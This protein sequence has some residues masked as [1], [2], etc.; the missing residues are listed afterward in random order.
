MAVVTNAENMRVMLVGIERYGPPIGHLAG[1][2]EHVLRYVRWAL[3]HGVPAEQIDVFASDPDGDDR[4]ASEANERLGVRLV[5]PATLNSIR[6]Y[7]KGEL[8]TATEQRLLLMW[9]GHG[10]LFS[11]T[12]TRLLYCADTSDDDPRVFSVAEM[13]KFLRSKQVQN[14]ERQ[15]LLFDVCA[16][17]TNLSHVQVPFPPSEVRFSL[18]S[19]RYVQE[20]ISAAR[21]GLSVTTGEFSRAMHDDVLRD[22]TGDEWPPAQASERVPERVRMTYKLLYGD[23]AD[24]GDELESPESQRDLAAAL[25]D[26]NVVAIVGGHAR[27]PAWRDQAE[28]AEVLAEDPT[29]R[30]P[31]HDR[32]NLAM[33]AEYVDRRWANG[34]AVKK[35]RPHLT[36]E[37]RTDVELRNGIRLL[38]RLPIDIYLTTAYDD[39]L[40]RALRERNREPTIRSFGDDLSNHEKPTVDRPLIFHLYGHLSEGISD[41]NAAVTEL[42]IHSRNQE[43]A[44]DGTIQQLPSLVRAALGRRHLYAGFDLRDRILRG[45]LHALRDAKQARGRIGYAVQPAFE[46]AAVEFTP[47]AKEFIAKY[48]TEIGPCKEVKVLWEFP[49]VLFS[50]YA[51]T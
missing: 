23:D 33:V 48:L 15:L 9:S 24:P 35:L 39:T 14:L 4:D 12:S 30:Y 18:D 43:I 11:G 19:A 3:D 22:W 16:L 31:F 50:K 44:A 49:E 7:V 8:R 26:G 45:L 1:P 20:A 42:D 13:L 29:V 40:A 28:L 41:D 25:D 32:Q 10:F 38:A 47:D 17:T 2:N 37:T 21:E 51:T 36:Q 34:D 27:R 5:R 46:V 6:D